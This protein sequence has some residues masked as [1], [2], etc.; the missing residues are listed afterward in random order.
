MVRRSPIRYDKRAKKEW[1]IKMI[2]SGAV[3]LLYLL[4]VSIDAVIMEKSDFLSS[5]DF[6][7]IFFAFLSVALF[8]SVPLFVISLLMFID[9]SLYLSRLKKNH[10]E[11]PEKKKLYENDLINLPRTQQVENKFVRDSLIGGCLYLIAY[12]V[13]V[14]LDI[15]YVVKWTRLGESDTIVLF[16]M[17]MLAHLFFLIFALYL[18]KQKDTTKYVDDVDIDDSCTRKARMSIAKSLMI[19]V[20]TSIVSAF[21]TG[22]IFTMTE[23]IYKS[24][25]G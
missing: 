18:F 6:M 4:V 24:R 11:L 25:Q 15:Y 7:F 13:F 2:I 9:S 12:L 21:G 10:F 19:L 8:V 17:M 3:I 16:V 20:I 14:A 23:Y 5:A 1:M 22:M